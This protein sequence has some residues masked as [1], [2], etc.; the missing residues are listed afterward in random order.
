M[1]STLTPTACF[2]TAPAFKVID[3]PY[4]RMNTVG[5][6]I[7]DHIVSNWNEKIQPLKSKSKNNANKDN[8]G[9][10]KAIHAKELTFAVTGRPKE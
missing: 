1:R 7:G 9:P 10:D 3:C 2:D 8:Q 4:D 6:E 5:E